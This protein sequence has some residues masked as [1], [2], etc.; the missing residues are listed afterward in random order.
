M[1]KLILTTKQ[2]E[3]ISFCESERFIV[4]EQGEW[5]SQGKFEI[6]EFVF[7]DTLTGQHYKAQVGRSGDYYS[8]YYYYYDSEFD[9]VNEV[10]LPVEEK[11][12]TRIEWASVDNNLIK[13]TVDLTKENI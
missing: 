8:D 2:L 7:Q 4:T 6:K 5:E 13:D 12:V 3:Q 1:N 11:T 9:N 10:L